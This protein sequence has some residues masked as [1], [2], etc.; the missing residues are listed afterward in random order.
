MKT[1]FQ[2]II[3]ALLIALMTNCSEEKA[4][5]RTTESSAST[6]IDSTRVNRI[7]SYKGFMDSIN[8]TLE[9]KELKCGLWLSNNGMLALKTQQ[10]TS[11]LIFID[12]YITTCADQ[13]LITLI[14]TASFAYLG[15][16]FYKDANNV[17]SHYTTSDGGFLRIV[18]DADVE[19]F[20]VLEGDYYG[21]DK[22][23]IYDGRNLVMDNVDHKT[24]RSLSDNGILGKDKNGY[25]QWNEKLDKE[26]FEN[27][28]ADIKK[29]LLKL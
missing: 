3:C 10:A 17:Y 13:D 4:H 1:T 12:R 14:D 8:E 24:F 11:E 2:Y 29:K 7:S 9:W 23:H 22:N 21:R 6:N 27:L 15:S 20:V 16:S 19:S 5:V 28:P 25:Y 18:K 26:S